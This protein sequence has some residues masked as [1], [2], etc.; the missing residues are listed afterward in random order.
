MAD[1]AL[2]R[3]AR[4]RSRDLRRGV[5]GQLWDLR[6]ERELSQLEVAA[7]AVMTALAS[8]ASAARPAKGLL[9]ADAR[10]LGMSLV[11]IATAWTVW[12]FGTADDNP[13][14][15]PGRCERSSDNPRIWFL[16]ISLGDLTETTCDVPQG[17]FVVMFAGGGEC[18]AAEPD[19]WHGDNEAEL[20]DCVNENFDLI[21]YQTITVDG[22]TTDALGAYVVRTRMVTL[23]A[24]NLLGPDPT[25]SMTKGYFAV[26]PPLSRGTHTAA[27]WTEFGSLD[28]AGGVDYV[29]NVH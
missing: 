18:S 17:A 3:L 22:T 28:F 20:I 6:E 26:I 21:T 24:D 29:I 4:A 16:P 5:G 7:A 14:F 13:N 2:R 12:G 10:P 23:P 11:D 27:N 19:P 1:T 25:I 9:P 15:A 8:G